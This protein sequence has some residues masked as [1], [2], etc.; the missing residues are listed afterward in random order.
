MTR[1][2][3]LKQRLGHGYKVGQHITT[4]QHF[5]A[6]L[7]SRSSVVRSQY[8]R[9]HCWF[10][11]CPRQRAKAPHSRIPTMACTLLL[12]VQLAQ[13]HTQTV[14]SGEAS[15][16]SANQHEPIPRLPSP[17][18]ARI[19]SQKPLYQVVVMVRGTTASK[20]VCWVIC[21]CLQLS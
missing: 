18:T 20:K 15:G 12:R 11:R 6:R 8:S 9:Q 2:P 1:V 5:A 19:C 10:R 14:E 16:R 4:F 17:R 7:W 21:Q 3:V 13:H